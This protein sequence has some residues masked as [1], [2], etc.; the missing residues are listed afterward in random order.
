MQPVV[1]MLSPEYASNTG[2]GK[3]I[4][5]PPSAFT[6]LMK[7]SKFSSTKC[8]IGIPKSSSMALMSWSGPW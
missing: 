8:W 7:L 5:I 3:Y 2:S 4:L 6:T 1:W